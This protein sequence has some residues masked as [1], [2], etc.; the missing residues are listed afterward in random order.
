MI[1]VRKLYMMTVDDDDDGNGHCHQ[2]IILND[3]ITCSERNSAACMNVISYQT[4]IFLFILYNKV[5]DTHL[6]TYNIH[7]S[8]YMLEIVANFDLINLVL[9]LFF[10]LY[11]IIHTHARNVLAVKIDAA[12]CMIQNKNADILF[13]LAIF[14]ISFLQIG[15][16]RR[17]KIS[18]N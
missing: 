4:N 15:K 3:F 6:S 7:E 10:S 8:S 1:L 16:I 13:L 2:P 11:P 5:Y 12:F 17:W 9:L 14:R 18:L